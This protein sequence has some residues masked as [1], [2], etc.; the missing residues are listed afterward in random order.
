MTQINK[1][2]HYHDTDCGGIVYYANYLKY[3]E[4]ARTEHMSIK[5][6]DLRELAKAGTLFVVRKVDIDYKSPARYGDNITILTEIT[7]IKNVSIEF[8]QEAKR[9]TKVLVSATTKLVCIGQDFSPKALSSKVVQCLK[10]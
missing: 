9:G 2:I 4:E 1:K 7:R 5:G 3:F 8:F 6:I 10:D